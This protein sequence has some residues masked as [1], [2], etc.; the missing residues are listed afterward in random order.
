MNKNRMTDLGKGDFRVFD[1]NFLAAVR[2]GNPETVKLMA[3]QD[4]FDIN[5][6]RDRVGGSA[7]HV[8]VDCDNLEMI[9]LLKELGLDPHIKDNKGKFAIHYATGPLTPPELYQFLDK[10]TFPEFAKR[11]NLPAENCATI[12]RFPGKAPQP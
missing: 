1:R 4:G 10:W 7:L 11:T 6:H 8:A 12:I 2:H 9:Q 3:S 5:S